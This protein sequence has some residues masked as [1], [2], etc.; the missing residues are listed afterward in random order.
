MKAITLELEPYQIKTLEQM[1][2]HHLVPYLREKAAALLK[3][4]SGKSIVDVAQHGLLKKRKTETVR[5]WV[6]A[7]NSHGIG[8]LY[9]L[10][11]RQRA[12]SPYTGGRAAKPVGAKPGKLWAG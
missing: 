3:I 7:Y 9:Q 8:G 6:K 11:R 4:A 10:R 12:F 2:D 5:G 1:R